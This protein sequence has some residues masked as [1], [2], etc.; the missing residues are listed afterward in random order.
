M[1]RLPIPLGRY[2]TVSVRHAIRYAEDAVSGY[3]NCTLM[4]SPLF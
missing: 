3:D 1:N 4:E 2:E